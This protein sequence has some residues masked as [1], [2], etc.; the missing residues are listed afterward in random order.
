MAM[1]VYSTTDDEEMKVGKLRDRFFCLIMLYLYQHFELHF[2]DNYMQ[3]AK[4]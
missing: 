4:M 3:I 1:S 2:V